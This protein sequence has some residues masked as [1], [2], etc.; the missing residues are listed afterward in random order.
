MNTWR[1]E[2]EKKEA[3]TM[4]KKPKAPTLCKVV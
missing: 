4:L 2:N 3:T 1:D